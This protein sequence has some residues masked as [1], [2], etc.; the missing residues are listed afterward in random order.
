MAA[1]SSLLKSA[2]ATQTKIRHAQDA[3]VAFEWQNSAQTYDDYLAYNDYLQ[4]NLAKAEDPTDALSYQTKMRG[5]FSSYTSNEIQRQSQA[6]MEGRATI[7]D[8]MQVV[9]RLYGQAVANGDMNLA[10]NLV[11]TWDS[12]SIQLQNEAKAAVTTRAAAASTAATDFKNAVSDMVSQYAGLMDQVTQASTLASNPAEFQQSLA[13]INQQLPDNVKL[14]D[15]Q[16]FFDIAATLVN[17]IGGSTANGSP[18]PN[19]ILGQAIQLAPDAATRQA[20]EKQYNTFAKKGVLT[21]ADGTQQALI[22]LPGVDGK[23]GKA[24]V[25]NLTPEDIQRQLAA[26]QIGETIYKMTPTKKG[27]VWSTNTLDGYV[28]GRDQNGNPVALPTYSIDGNLGQKLTDAGGNEIKINKNNKQVNANYEEL[29]KSAGFEVTK[30]DGSIIVD[31]PTGQGRLAGSDRAQVYI[32]RNGRLQFVDN[33]NDIFNFN[34]AKD[35]K[36]NG[37]GKEIA[38]PFITAGANGSLNQNSPYFQTHQ[39]DYRQAYGTAGLLTPQ[40][41]QQF[42]SAVG[43]GRMPTLPGAAGTPTPRFSSATSVLQNAQQIQNT[44]AQQRAAAA[45]QAQPAPQIQ[46]SPVPQIQAPALNPQ[47]I[48]SRNATISVAPN[49][50]PRPSISIAPA[51]APKPTVTVQKKAPKFSISF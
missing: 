48:S 28:F 21:L 17:A 1:I 35:G 46:A 9:E 2:Q 29:L 37:I 30:Q 24:T 31:D 15:G 49:V 4:K 50:A 12:L 45:I 36:F 7:Q 43:I 25:I 34:F 38:N 14:Q 51:P 16:D 39:E 8:K 42:D 44:I 23:T 6:V 5:A 10:Q 40:S 20:L 18:D 33:N 41:V 32:D 26:A 19:S 22:S 3:Q 11:T 47:F 13:K 27:T